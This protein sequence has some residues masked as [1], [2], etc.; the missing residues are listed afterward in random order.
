MEAGEVH[1]CVGSKEEVGGNNTNCIQ[2]SDHDEAHGYDKDEDVA[3]PGVVIS[4]ESLGKPE[5]SW[6]DSV[7][8]HGLQDS[9][10]PHHAGNGR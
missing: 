9:R 3:S 1:Q 8:P 2:L 6:I 4:I 5:D 10:R 7:L